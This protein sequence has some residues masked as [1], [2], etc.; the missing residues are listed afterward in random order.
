MIGT[1]IKAPA[2]VPGVMGGAIQFDGTTNYVDFDHSTALRLVGSMTVTAWIRAASFPED[3]ATIVSR[4]NGLG[5]QF[6]TTVDQGPRTIG[7]K[8]ADACGGYMARYGVT[9]LALNTWYH[10][11][12]VYN[13]EA[14]TLDV[15][16]NGKRD[17][18]VLLGS[19]SGS[20]RSSRS[21][22]YVGRRS[23]Q[24]GYEFSGAI[25]DV[26]IY[27]LALTEAEIAAT[28]QG[29]SIDRAAPQ[30]PGAADAA[31][32]A[33][34]D[35]L[36]EFAPPCEGLSDREDSRIPLAAAALGLLAAMVCLS[37]WPTAGPAPLLILGF[38]AGLPLLPFATTALLWW[39][40]PLVSLAGGASV[41]VAVRRHGDESTA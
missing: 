20:Q 2:R 29:K 18:G 10:L 12:G 11:A 17:N 32:R 38:M 30:P 9:P 39:G 6:D 22:V 19:V 28:M 41:A 31:P 15:Y 14:K 24:Q 23:D 3:D 7:Y 5:Y 1:L 35:R 37:L 16:L 33:D 8:I 25:D 4:F 26:R 36:H 21:A 13:A 27:S 40:T 34:A